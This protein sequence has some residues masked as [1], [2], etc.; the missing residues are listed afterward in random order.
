MTAQGDIV[1]V[2]VPTNFLV[3]QTNVMIHLGYCVKAFRIEE[4][5]PV[6]QA[7]IAAHP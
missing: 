5:L 1:P 4:L 2:P 6:V 7:Y 3:A